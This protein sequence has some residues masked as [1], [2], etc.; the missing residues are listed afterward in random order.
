MMF[1]ASR[2]RLEVEEC[3]ICCHSFEGGCAK[4]TIPLFFFAEKKLETT[5][6]FPSR[7][8]FGAKKNIPCSISRNC[9]NLKKNLIFAHDSCDSGLFSLSQWTRSDD[10]IVNHE[11]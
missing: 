1:I 6:F 7:C 4:N 8:F 5:G 3:K 9:Q 2:K 11:E 10:I